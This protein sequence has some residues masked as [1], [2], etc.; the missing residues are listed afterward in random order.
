VEHPRVLQLVLSLN[1]GGTER[2]VLELTK[3]LHAEMP[4][5][6]CCLDAPGAWA[7]ELLSFNIDVQAL[8]REEGFQ[9]SL[10]RRVAQL[11]RRHRADVIH[12][13][14][15]SPLVY[16]CLARVWRPQTRVVFTEHG[17][18]SDAR[19]SRKRR[20][21]NQ[22]FARVPSAAFAVS[23]ELRQHLVEEGFPPDS[24]GV[25]YN[26]IDPVGSSSRPSR[27]E[28]RERL[29]IVDDRTLV[30]GTVA[31]LDPVKDLGTLIRGVGELGPDVP[32]LLAIIGDG[33]ERAGLEAI[34]RDLG[35]Q[36][37]VRFLGQRNDARDWLHGCDAYVNSSI[38]E[39]VSLTILE[40]MAA[41]LPIVATAVGGTP[42][43][44]DDASALLIPARSPQAVASALVRLHQDP[45]LRARMGT[46]ALNRVQQMFTLDRMV[47]EYRDVYER[48]A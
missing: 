12:C 41:S 28:I 3:R 39:G 6:V 35:V 42:E 29:G 16:G 25:I 32:V 43:V 47:R 27:G 40:A 2:L 4:M 33:T 19:P 36:A 31:R 26:G 20:L 9:P 48:V 21:A 23:R 18:L 38:S 7:S 11:A 13:H 14:H 34:A 24:I 8:N 5:A 44:V 17:R 30:V 45:R 22:V 15:Y 46:A 37:R 1:P 10:G